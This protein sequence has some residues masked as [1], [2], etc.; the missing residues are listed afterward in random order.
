MSVATR[1]LKVPAHQPMQ[2]RLWL[3][4]SSCVRLRDEFLN[5]EIFHTLREGRVLT[6]A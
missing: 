5:G 4:D 2:A 3:H 1:G 6:E